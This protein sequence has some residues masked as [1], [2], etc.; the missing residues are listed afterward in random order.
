MDKSWRLSWSRTMWRS[1]KIMVSLR[2]FL[3]YL[4]ISIRRVRSMISVSFRMILQALLVRSFN[5][6]FLASPATI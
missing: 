5:C 2:N 3:V 6:R 4:T 1:S